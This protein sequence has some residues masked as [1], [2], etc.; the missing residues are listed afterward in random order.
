MIDAVHSIAGRFQVVRTELGS[1]TMDFRE[2][3]C[4]QLEEALA[5]RGVDYHFPPLGRRSPTR[6]RAFEDMMAAFQ[7]Q[8]PDQGLLFIVDELLDYLRTRK[9]QELI[10]D[11]NFLREVGEV[12][13]I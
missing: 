2:F 10:L 4:T 8:F 6:S 1:T 11:F 9:D 5:K 13:K 3:V 12:C 7:K